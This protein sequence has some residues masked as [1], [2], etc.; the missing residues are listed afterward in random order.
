MQVREDEKT[1]KK[2]IACQVDRKTKNFTIMRMSVDDEWSL[3]SC[4]KVRVKK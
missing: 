2:K 4:T 1:W 3:S